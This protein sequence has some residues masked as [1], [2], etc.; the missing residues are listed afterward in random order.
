MKYEMKTKLQRVVCYLLLLLCINGCVSV[1][2]TNYEDAKRQPKPKDFNVKV[3]DLANVEREYK[4]VGNIELKLSELY[5]AEGA[6]A[7]IRKIAG[8]MG[9][10][11][12]SDVS[13]THLPDKFPIFFDYLNFYA[14]LWTAEVIVWEE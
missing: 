6:F 9:G 10:D 13:Q 12:V 5:S 11:A 2:V 14:S 4:T 1:S 3:L 7:R 8:K